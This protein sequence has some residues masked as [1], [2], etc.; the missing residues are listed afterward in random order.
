MKCVIDANILI[1][2]NNGDILPLL[3]KLTL[4]IS[5]PDLVL[6]ELIKPDRITL[7]QMGVRKLVLSSE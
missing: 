5:T 6:D 7:L 2:L 4:L 1:V 3:F